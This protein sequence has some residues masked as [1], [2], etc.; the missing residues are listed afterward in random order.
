M[1]FVIFDY[2]QIPWTDI[3]DIPA[4]RGDGP[5]SDAILDSPPW[6]GEGMMILAQW[7]HYQSTSS[8]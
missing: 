2:S 1:A 6:L 4:L 7:Q 5:G 8:R 3:V